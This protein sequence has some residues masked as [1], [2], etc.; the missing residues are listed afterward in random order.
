[1]LTLAIETSGPVGSV[2]LL[3]ARQVLGEEELE[4]GRQHGQELIPAIHRL[5]SGCDRKPGDLELVAV[6]VGPGSYT[7]LRVGVVCAKT[8]VYTTRCRLA[9]VDTFQAIAGNSPADLST[10]EVI[11]DAQRGDLFRG[12]YARTADGRWRRDGGIE[13]IAAEVWAAGLSADDVLS[14]PGINKFGHL[15]GGRCRVL[16]PECRIPRAGCVAR[17]GIEA[18]E[19]GLAADFWSIEPLYLRRSSAEVQWEKLHP[20]PFPSE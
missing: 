9:A 18:I 4:L 1:M 11:G 6:S 16:P 7:G 13:V 17:L 20:V 10:I 19:A 5:F 3:N 12:R 15:V 14:G 8:L 2:A